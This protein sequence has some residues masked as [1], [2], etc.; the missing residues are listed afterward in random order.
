[1]GSSFEPF[2][3]GVEGFGW[4]CGVGDEE[5]VGGDGEAGLVAEEED[6]AEDFEAEGTAA[7]AVFPVLA[8]CCE[9]FSVEEGVDGAAE[10]VIVGFGTT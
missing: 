4:D 1:L 9:G 2:D 7:V 8:V 6:V 3:T 10:G 5:D